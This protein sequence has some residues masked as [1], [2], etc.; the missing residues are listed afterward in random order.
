MDDKET[1]FQSKT[2]RRLSKKYRIMFATI[3]VATILAAIAAG[4]KIA[5]MYG[6]II[7]IIAAIAFSFVIKLVTSA[8]FGYMVGSEVRDNFERIEKELEDIPHDKQN[9]RESSG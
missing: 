7:G 8:I 1:L 2:A 5:V 6:I 4:R 3:D 9:E